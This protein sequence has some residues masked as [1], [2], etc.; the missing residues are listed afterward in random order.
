LGS[1]LLD[2]PITSKMAAFNAWVLLPN[3][4]KAV[5]AKVEVFVDE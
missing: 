4:E 1:T 5:E 2:P 3:K